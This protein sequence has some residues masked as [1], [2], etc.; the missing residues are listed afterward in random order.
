MSKLH[1]PSYPFASFSLFDSAMRDRVSLQPAILVTVQ[2]RHF[3]DIWSLF[4]FFGDKLDTDPG[5]RL[6]NSPSSLG[7]HFTPPV[8]SYT[9]SRSST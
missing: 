9:L 3:E 2:A 5:S 1:T 6:V 8:Y 4:F 7:L